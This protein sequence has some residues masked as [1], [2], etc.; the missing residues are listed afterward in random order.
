M[1]GRQ[2]VLL[3]KFHAFTLYSAFNIVFIVLGL[4]VP[5]YTFLYFFT[6]RYSVDD[7]ITD[8]A[9]CTENDIKSNLRHVLL[10]YSEHSYKKNKKIKKIERE[11]TNAEPLIK[12]SSFV[13]PYAQ[14]FDID[15]YRGA[16]RF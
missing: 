11:Y 12:L 3:L 6:S 5:V 8:I 4:I 9:C 2:I 7:I 15:H 14:V 16:A 10:R 13:Y 1:S